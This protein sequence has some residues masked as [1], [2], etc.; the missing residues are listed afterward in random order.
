MEAATLVNV[1]KS[2]CEVLVHH[3]EIVAGSFLNCYG[4]P[5]ACPLLLLTRLLCDLH[6]SSFIF[7]IAFSAKIMEYFWNQIVFV[8]L[9]LLFSISVGEK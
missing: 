1:T 7:I 9:L 8:A 3:F 2:G 4:Q 5:F 6:L